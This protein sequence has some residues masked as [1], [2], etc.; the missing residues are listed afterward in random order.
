MSH[1]YFN[2]LTVCHLIMNSA[3]GEH[4][5]SSWYARIQ[6]TWEFPQWNDIL[7]LDHWFLH[8]EHL[9]LLVDNNEFSQAAMTHRQSQ[10]L[11]ALSADIPGLGNQIIEWQI[12]LLWIW[13]MYYWPLFPECHIITPLDTTIHHTHWQFHSEHGY[14]FCHR[15]SGGIPLH[16]DDLIGAQFRSHSSISVSLI[17]PAIPCWYT[18]L[19]CPVAPVNIHLCLEFP[20]EDQ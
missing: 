16:N 10:Q 4:Y 18:Y 5:A 7:H 14:W 15:K 20:G 13:T 6:T 9:I 12:Q 11:I 2:H 3:T 1:A 19:L 8:H 17:G